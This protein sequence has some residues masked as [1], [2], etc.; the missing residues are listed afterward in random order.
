MLLTRQSPKRGFTLIELLVVIAILGIISSIVLAS[1]NDSRT[2]GRDAARKTQS[3][4]IIKALEIYYADYNNYP[5]DGNADPNAGAL[6]NSIHVSFYGT[7]QYINRPPAEDD[8][9]YFYCASANGKSMVLAVDTEQDK[10]GPEWCHVLRGPG[11]DYG[12]NG[13]LQANANQECSLRF[14]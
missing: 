4:E 7:N 5:A 12:C 10:G 1:V 9:R 11:P 6:L 14:R 3:Q 13:W 2:K 8:S